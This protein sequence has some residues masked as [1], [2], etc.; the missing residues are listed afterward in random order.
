MAIMIPRHP[1]E[2]DP[3][4]KEDE[5]FNALKSLP[6][7]YYVFHS[8]ALLKVFKDYEYNGDYIR[9]ERQ[10]DFVVF[11]PQKGIICIEAKNWRDLSYNNGLNGSEEGWYLNGQL[12]ENARYDGPFEQASSF[13]RDFRDRLNASSNNYVRDAIYKS[14]VLPAVWL[15]SKH[16]NDIKNMMLPGNV[17]RGSILSF[18]DVHNRTALEEKIES[19]F[20]TKVYFNGFEVTHFA[21]LSPTES[22]ALI[23]AIAPNFTV[24]FEKYAKETN[25]IVFNQLLKQQYAVLDFL[26]EQNTAVIS[27]VAGTGKTMLATRKAEIHA[28]EGDKVLYLCFNS[29]L[30]KEL[31]EDFDCDN[32]EY[33]TLDDYCCKVCGHGFNSDRKDEFYAECLNALQRIDLEKYPF[34][35]I[36]LDEGQDICINPLIEKILETIKTII[37]IKEGTFYIFYDKMQLLPYTDRDHSGKLPQIITDADCKLTLYRNCRNTAKIAR[38]ATVTVTPK[39]PLMM[40][41]APDGDNPL[42]CYCDDI[43]L[44]KDKVERIITDLLKKGYVRKDIV[45]LSLKGE[46]NKMFGRVDKINGVRYTTINKFK[47]LEAKAVIIVDFDQNTFETEENCTLYYVAASRAREKLFVITTMTDGNASGINKQVFKWYIQGINPQQAVRS[48]TDRRSFET[49]IGLRRFLI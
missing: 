45:V 8:V 24:S 36:I 26:Q 21:P 49:A 23:S 28:K 38:S 11:H 17:E 34:K 48:I 35:H 9:E 31:S 7:D 1:K 43:L 40:E 14:K 37:E 18:E 6:N 3:K 20:N 25:E 29:E 22:T 10:I 19:I 5:V 4:S 2:F 13:C 30:A 27:G 46:S 33:A 32:V 42:I 41:T 47:G 44:I 15:I 16:D 12:Y 39:P